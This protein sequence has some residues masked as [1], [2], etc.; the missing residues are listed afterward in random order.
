LTGSTIAQARAAYQSGGVWY[1]PVQFNSRR[2]AQASASEI[3]G[4]IIHEIGHTL[5]FGW[6]AWQ[7]LFNRQTGKFNNQAVARLQ[8][9]ADMVVELE[10]GDGTAL[11]HWDEETFGRELMTGYYD[12]SLYVLPVTIDVL[13]LLGHT[14]FQRLAKP[15]N[16]DEL[17]DQVSNLVFSRQ[18]EAL[19][20]DLDYF[21][22]TEIFET[23]PHRP[24][25]DA[26]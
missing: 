18:E 16:L 8:S 25:P 3:V 20:L 4:T 2:L 6:N 7:A 13:G 19:S 15:T 17:L 26:Q 22:E 14:V 24:D 1:G 9:L 10:G 21:E 12:P 11:S 23:I 5:G